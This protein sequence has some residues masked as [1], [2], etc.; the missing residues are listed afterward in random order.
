MTWSY[1]QDPSI[2]TKDEV[3]FYVGDTDDTDQQV[4]NEEIE[5]AITETASARGAAALVARAIAAKYARLADQSVGDLRFSYSQR[6]EHYTDLAERLELQEGRRFMSEMY[7]GGI[8]ESEK[9]SVESNTDRVS[10]NFT[11]GMHDNPGSD[12]DREEFCE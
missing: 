9:R 11:I 7:A 6:Q 2:S 12:T 10:P 4:Q 8:S 3:R 1:S 5:W